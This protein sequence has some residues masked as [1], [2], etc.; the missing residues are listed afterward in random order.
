MSRDP[1]NARRKERKGERE[2]ERERGRESE[3][4]RGMVEGTADTNMA[5]RLKAMHRRYVRQS[6]SW[7]DVGAF[8]A[9]ISTT[10]DSG[11]LASLPSSLSL[12]F[13]S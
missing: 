7:H 4:E 5:N 11:V 8:G 10:I 13:F 9:S 3:K 6:A 1:E 2:R 12:L